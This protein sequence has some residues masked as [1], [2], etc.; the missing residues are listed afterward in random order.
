MRESA[1]LAQAGHCPAEGAVGEGSRV[2]KQLSHWT[3]STCLANK[4][5]ARSRSPANLFAAS[6][7]IW[8]VFLFRTTNLPGAYS[9]SA[10]LRPCCG[11]SSTRTRRFTVS[12]IRTV[13]KF[14]GNA[15][16][17]STALLKRKFNTLSS[18][19]GGC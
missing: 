12:S 9:E 15:Y 2:W 10:T 6:E 13:N 18:G 14:R 1:P 11:C 7:P 5:R 17:G 4:G 16:A 3:Y 8:Y 19:G